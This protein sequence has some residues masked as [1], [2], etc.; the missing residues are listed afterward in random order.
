MIFFGGTCIF[1]ATYSPAH[2]EN[3]VYYGQPSCM[4]KRRTQGSFLPFIILRS[5]WQ[6]HDTTAMSPPQFPCL[7]PSPLHSYSHS[8]CLLRLSPEEGDKHLSGASPCVLIYPG[9]RNGILYWR[10]LMP[11]IEDGLTFLS[12]PF[13]LAMYIRVSRGPR[14]VC[15]YRFFSISTLKPRS[16][17]PIGPCT[18]GVLL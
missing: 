13:P 16:G 5:L 1:S 2:L 11:R 6:R 4:R 3:A 9:T 18:Y 7:P 12:S 14:G 17:A 15:I 8:P 10:K